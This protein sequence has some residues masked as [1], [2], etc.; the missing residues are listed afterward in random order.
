MS[1][2]AYAVVWSA[3]LEILEDETGSAGSCVVLNAAGTAH[4]VA[5]SA[6]RT[7]ASRTTRISGIML[8]DA[9]A[10]NPAF[11][12][13]TVGIVPRNVINLGAGAAGPVICNASGQPERSASP[14]ASDVVIGTCDA[15]GTIYLGSSGAA[16][17]PGGAN[18]SI[19]YNKD[20]TF[21]GANRWYVYDEASSG[22]IWAQKTSGYATAHIAY[23]DV[24]PE[25]TPTNYPESGWLRMGA[26]I[27]DAVVSKDTGE[28]LRSLDGANTLG[29]SA[30]P[31][32]ILGTG[33]AGD[34]LVHDGTTGF[35]QTAQGGWITALDLDLAAQS[36][37]TLGTD[38]TFT[39]GG[40]TW[41]KR[42]STNDQSAMAIVAGSGL[43]IQPKST[44]DWFSGSYTMPLLEI[45]L[46]S[47]HA[48]IAIG[49]RVRIWIYISADNGAAN[50]DAVCFGVSS[51][52]AVA[53]HHAERGRTG[54]DGNVT[55]ITSNLTASS[56][57]TGLAKAV[58]INST[59]NVVVLDIHAL[60]S[61]WVTAYYGSYSSGF[62]AEA[63]LLLAR[64]YAS[65]SLDMSGLT[66]SNMALVLGARRAGSGT[67]Y[68][69]TIA[70]VKVEFR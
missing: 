66:P 63:T 27:V 59:S 65:G 56:T 6:A 45:A 1:E 32:K 31:S 14:S 62:P 20:F 7:A 36:N 55:G 25:V 50:Y 19:Q 42:N 29:N 53:G 9:D 4:N 8:T 5:T 17:I 28:V 15:D 57:S 21:G 48:S 18:R 61:P 39:I 33:N 12:M 43:V 68:S 46:Q 16:G 30:Y 51:G 64:S 24:D 40:K 13:R 67:S 69:A 3:T 38:T 52:S 44:G 70:R 49:K 2:P 26:G 41:T 23:G 22:G 11:D 54:I 37:Q 60:G 10:T 47:L 34:V 35:V 58:A